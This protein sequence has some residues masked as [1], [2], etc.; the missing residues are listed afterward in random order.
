MSRATSTLS[1]IQPPTASPQPSQNQIFLLDH[2]SSQAQASSTEPAGEQ[3][4]DAERNHSEAL[5]P[6]TSSADPLFKKIT[7]NSIQDTVRQQY[8]KQKYARYQSDRYED[9]AQETSSTAAQQGG[10]PSTAAQKSYNYLE[11]GRGQ[12]R[13]LLKGKKDFGRASEKDV[14]FDILYENQRGSF[15]FGSPRFS[16]N[17]LLNFDPNPWQNAAFR[18]S[19]VDIRNAQVPDPSWEWAWKSWYVDMSRDVDEEGWEYS[20]AFP[21]QF[22]WHGNHPWFHSFVRRRRWLRKRVRKDALHKTKNKSHELAPDYFTI[23]T[24]LLSASSQDD[25]RKT[26]RAPVEDEIGELDIPDMGSLMAV[27]RKS[28]IDREKLGAIRRFA[29]QGGGDLYYLSNRMPEIMSLFIYQSSRRQV[30][31]ELMHHHGDAT[32]R[33]D[34][35]AGHSHDDDE[36]RAFHD[37]ASQQAEHL[38]SAI[39]AA[40]EQ[41]QKLEYWSDIRDMAQ[42]GETLLGKSSGDWDA[43]RW[44]GLDTDQH[45]AFKSKQ[46]AD[47]PAAELHDEPETQDKRTKESSSGTDSSGYTTAPS[48]APSVA[49]RAS[50]KQKDDDTDLDLERYTTASETPNEGKDKQWRRAKGKNRALNLDGVQEEDEGAGR[51]DDRGDVKAEDEEDVKAEDG[52]DVTAKDEGYAQA[53]VE[54]EAQAEEKAEANCE[55]ANDE[56]VIQDYVP[57]RQQAGV[58][59]VAP[60]SIDAEGG[61]PV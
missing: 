30:L 36:A 54:E 29:N 40:D 59:V 19:A 3:Q 9:H 31:A 61:Q 11:R 28:K 48:L 60:E 16:S 39:K 50:R 43:K 17:S 15:L 26:T 42:H 24:K 52:G 46:Q 12:V 22:A 20:L 2:S 21:N 53:E 7:S 47:D 4:R 23:H 57:P 32:E 55:E 5:S 33:R 41:V 14:I 8:S 6:S 18:T 25:A 45:G 10:E 44:Q 51:P 38:L 1:T 34:S 13:N 27:L 56:E 49:T 58:D 37:A 35:L